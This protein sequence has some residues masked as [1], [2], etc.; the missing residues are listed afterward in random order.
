MK[1]LLSISLLI[2]W[3]LLN[4]SR[5]WNYR[6][7]PAM[8]LISIPTVTCDCERSSP[9]AST[10]TDNSQPGAERAAS[11]QK[12]EEVFAGAIPLALTGLVMDP[13]PAGSL[14]ITRKVFA[15][16]PTALFQPPRC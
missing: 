8:S 1:Q 15:G 7:C 3:L 4:Y 6:S 14:F 2:L 12:P 16:Y 9:E 5:I 10:T 13:L 11:K